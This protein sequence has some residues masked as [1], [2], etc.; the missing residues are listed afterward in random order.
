VSFVHFFLPLSF[1][2]IEVPRKF[3]TWCLDF[4]RATPRFRVL[5]SKVTSRCTQTT[6]V[7]WI[8]IKEYEVEVY[9]HTAVPCVCYVPRV[10]YIYMVTHHYVTYNITW[11]CTLTEYC[12]HIRRMHRKCYYGTSTSTDIYEILIRLPIALVCLYSVK[13]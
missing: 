7:V 9:N 3:T 5:G 8:V 1:A 4:L 2:Q 10:P 13:S 12:T 6:C 11:Y